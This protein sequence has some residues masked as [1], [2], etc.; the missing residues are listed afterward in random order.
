[1]KIGGNY[2]NDEVNELRV[3]LTVAYDGTDFVGWQ[4][5]AK[6]RSVQGDLEKNLRRLTGK[7]VSVQ[8]AG[9]TDAGVHGY[10][11][12]ASFEADLQLPV[13]NLAYALNNLLPVD[14]RV[15]AAEEA[16]ED[17]HARF[18]P[19]RKE[20]R[21]FLVPGEAGGPFMGRYGWFCP[22]IADLELMQQAARLLVGEH[23]FR[24]FCGKSAVV[25]TYVRTLYE[26]ELRTA[27]ADEVSDPLYRL[28]AEGKV[29]MLRLV[30]NGFIYKM[31]R[32]LTGGLVKVGQGKLSMAEFARLL[33]EPAEQPPAPAAPAQGLYLW[34][35]D[36]DVDVAPTVDRM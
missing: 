31:V 1:M 11:Q 14:V 4:R 24:S 33:S 9:R 26:A 36:Y 25:T 8:G 20:Y 7:T 22:L 17:F 23:N 35:L 32:L 12:V 27:G 34:R 21:Y 29:L 10:G 5:Q 16:A 19:S 13:A 6:G 18:T 15:L 30:G 28:A 2:Q 3:K